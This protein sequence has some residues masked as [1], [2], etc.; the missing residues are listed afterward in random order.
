M[1]LEGAALSTLVGLATKQPKWSLP[2]L[3]LLWPVALPALGV[4]TYI[5]YAPLLM[6]LRSN[7]MFSMMLGNAGPGLPQIQQPTQPPPN[8]DALFKSQEG[9][10]ELERLIKEAQEASTSEEEDNET[11]GE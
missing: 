3:I 5:K 11:K 1:F 9:P 10:S 8:L 2:F 4:R 7:P 6:Q